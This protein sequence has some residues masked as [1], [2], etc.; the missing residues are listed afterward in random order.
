MPEATN[1][2][3]RIHYEAFG[4]TDGAETVVLISGACSDHTLWMSQVEALMSD[5]R[6]IALDNRGSG[7]SDRPPGP[8]T[9]ELMASDVMQLLTK[10]E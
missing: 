5:F 10:R 9:A 4:D 7:K 2:N 1:D 8:Y 3:V 6:V